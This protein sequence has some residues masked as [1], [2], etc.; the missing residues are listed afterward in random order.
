M[1]VISLFVLVLLITYCFAHL[2]IRVTEK[3]ANCN[4]NVKR[5]TTVHLH[6]N[7]Y[8]NNG[9]NFLKS[10]QNLYSF[11][12]GSNQVVKGLNNAVI[13][14]CVGEKRNVKMDSTLGYGDHR[15]GIIEPNSELN[16]DIE[17]VRMEN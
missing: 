1:K 6:L 4:E 15:R 7:G 2:E 13:G 12:V 9:R 16:Y 3:P 10:E 11:K 14:M 5:G 17:L 8:L